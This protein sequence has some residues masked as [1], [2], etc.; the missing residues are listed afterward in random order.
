MVQSVTMRCSAGVLVM[1]LC[2][3]QLQYGGGAAM[4]VCDDELGR[5]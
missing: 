1:Q 5:I 4:L 3:V 2:L